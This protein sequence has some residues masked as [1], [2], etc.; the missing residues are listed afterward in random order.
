M[1][2]KMR[3]LIF[4]VVLSVLSTISFSQNS[5]FEWAK[6]VGG[7]EYE[8]GAAIGV[9]DSG[10]VYT[11]GSYEG[12][13]D[14]DPGSGITNL[15][16]IAD[17]D[18]YIT[19]LD[20]AGNFIWAKS[21]GG[22]DYEELQAIA[23]DGAGNVYAT[24]YFNGTVDFDP[25]A[26]ISNITAIGN[27]SVFIFKLDAS[28]NFVWAKNFDGP[29]SEVGYA[30]TLDAAGNVYTTGLFFSTADF[31]PG[32]GVSN[33]TSN[34]G[35]D[36]FICKLDAS[37][38]FV[39]AKSIGGMNA[40]GGRSISIDANGNVYTAGAY[41]G[42]VDFDPGTGISNL[43]AVG[44]DDNIFILKLDVAGNFIWAK[45][46]QAEITYLGHM[47]ALDAG[48]NAYITGYFYNVVDFDPGAGTVNGT[49]NG[50]SDVFILKLDM[51]GNFNWV[52]TFGGQNSDLANAI[53]LDASGNIFTFGSF[54]ELVDFD[55]GS[56]LFELTSNG[57][58]DMFI[59]KLN[60]AGDFVW[61]KSI[62]GIEQDRAYSI[63]VDDSGNIYGI[64]NFA[65]AVDFDPG[66]DSSIL[67]SNG[68]EDDVFILKL[69]CEIDA[70][71]TLSAY[72]ISANLA[73]ATYQWI[74]CDNGNAIL[75]GETNQSYTAIENGNYAVMVTESSC[76]NT[77]ACVSITGL[78]IDN[79][80]L[81]NRAYQLYPNPST[82]TITISNFDS[83][84]DNITIVDITGKVIQSFQPK[85][86]DIDVSALKKGVYFIQIEVN[87]S[88]VCKKFIKV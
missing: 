52:K 32:T 43:T 75:P 65:G 87:K 6:S 36:I 69:R 37:G 67:V 88:F 35:S 2:Y 60:A 53:T 82:T 22:T 79:L 20:A 10:N 18:M 41:S 63:K 57:V 28:G 27:S 61:A 19:K 77:S 49:S 54:R 86:G 68:I 4:T 17:L 47:L 24:G 62:G 78:D 9:D 73:G 70:T 48:G 30:I 50:N 13:V 39:W 26:G 56:G 71:T 11:A 3:K 12:T 76:T 55:P 72:T 21:I 14:F 29:S 38:N 25:G 64:G 7:V 84:I 51:A 74:D 42:T 80:D 40:D 8:E 45:S 85:T 31:D 44:S 58:R 81:L 46:I 1:N 59:S 34:G 66:A 23:V 16:S 15:T 83:E 33:L 5:V